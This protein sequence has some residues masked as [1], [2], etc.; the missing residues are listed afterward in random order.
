MRYIMNV[1]V[2]NRRGLLAALLGAVC[3]LWSGNAAAEVVTLQELEELA[4]RN[5]ANWEAVDARADRAEAEVSLAKAA[6]RPTITLDAAGYAAPGARIVEVPT[7]EGDLATV[8]ASPRVSDPGAFLARAR[9]DGHIRI[10]A[11]LYDFGRTK[12]AIR[13]AETYRAAAGAR[14]AASR[15]DVIAAVRT[16]YLLWLEAYVVH[17]LATTSA[18]EASKQR[19][20]VEA[21]VEDGQRHGVDL[22]DAQYDEAQER[23]A[24]SDAGARLVSAKRELEYMVGSALS[25]TAEPDISLLSIEPSGADPAVESSEIDAIERERDAAQLEARMHR[26]T[27]A[28]VLAA[29]GQ[30]GFSGVDRDVFPMYR[31]GLTFAVPL[32]DAGV[33]LARAHA[34]EAQATELDARLRDKRLAERDEKERAALDRANA[35]EQLDI[36]DTLVAVCEKRVERAEARYELGAGELDGISAARAALRD[37]ESRRVHVRVARA[38]AI[39]RMDD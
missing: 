8:S 3:A 36:V 2:C 12:A 17:E 30:T 22:D 28:P 10:H 37:A 9:Y 34:I 13:S 6:R 33:A 15:E 23:L 25:P 24:A 16:S 18:K 32:Y 4:L 11:P 31:L 21:R 26:L 1:R 7:V 14:A 20:R 38:D 5:Q 39:L 29:M 19:A 35:E 27:R